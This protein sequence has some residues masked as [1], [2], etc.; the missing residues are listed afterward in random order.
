MS[1]IIELAGEVVPKGRPKFAR[2]GVGQAPIAYTPAKTRKYESDL[3]LAAAVAMQGKQLIRGPVWMSITVTLP[4][5]T[6][7]TKKKQRAAA[8]QTLWPIKKPDL[9][10]FWK[11]AADALNLVVFLDDSQIV[12]S[13]AVKRYGDRPGIRIEVEEIT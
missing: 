7:W 12:T 4:I 1:I 3:R 2:R 8:A 5:R 9:D 11:A 6:S 13:I 10:N